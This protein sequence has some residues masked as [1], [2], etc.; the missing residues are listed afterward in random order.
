M[1]NMHV[2]RDLYPEGSKYPTQ[3]FLRLLEL[4][5]GYALQFLGL[6]IGHSGNCGG[7]L[8][9]EGP[10]FNSCFEPTI[11]TFKK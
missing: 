5:K 6:F 11:A 2:L 9:G 7:K 4:T 1:I 3:R 8:T 10:K